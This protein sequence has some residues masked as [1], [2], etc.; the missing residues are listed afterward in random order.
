MF[1]LTDRELEALRRVCEA[2][3]GRN[4]SEFARTELLSS[5]QSIGV[6][7]LI[8]QLASMEQHVHRLEA[9]YEESIRLV[10]LAQA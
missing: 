4:L 7:A 3:G 2:K 10:S 1:R 5:A 8:H 9:W 6:A